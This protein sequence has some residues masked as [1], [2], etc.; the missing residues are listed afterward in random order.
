MKFAV[1]VT[2]RLVALTVASL[3]LLAT[4]A[5]AQPDGA[6]EAMKAAHENLVSVLDQVE[7]LFYKK[8]TTDDGSIFYTVMWE[9]DGETTKIILGLKE[10]GYFNS[11]YIYG[12]SAWTYVVSSDTPVPPAVIKLVASANDSLAI[13]SYSTSADYTNVYANMSGVLKNTTPDEIWMYIAYLHSNRMKL[14][15]QVDQAMAGASQ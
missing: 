7:D 9:A 1:P 8:K 14:K 12:L 4:P 15:Q 13:G 2:C 5:V 10:L 11:K 6:E 3:C